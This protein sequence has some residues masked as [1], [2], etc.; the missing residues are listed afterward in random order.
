M[1]AGDRVALRF[2]YGADPTG[3]PPK[4][5][6]WLWGV[7]GTFCAVKGPKGEWRGYPIGPVGVSLKLQRQQSTPP[8]A[9]PGFVTSASSATL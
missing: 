6:L 7:W 2:H 8:R 5:V 3:K 1:R 4:D 9:D